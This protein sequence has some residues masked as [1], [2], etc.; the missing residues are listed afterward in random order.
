MNGLPTTRNT[1]S[2]SP[3]W[4]FNRRTL[5][6]IGTVSIVFVYWMFLSSK[7][8]LKSSLVTSP[9][10]ALYQYQ[11]AY[12]KYTPSSTIFRVAI[13]ADP[14]KRSK[15]EEKG[16]WQSKLR[17]GT[18]TRDPNTGNYS[19]LWDDE[20]TI[21]ESKYS[22]AGRSM[23]LSELVNFNHKLL[24]VDDRTGIVYSIENGKAIPQHILME[25][26]GQ[27]TKGFKAEWA[28]VKDGLLYIG[29]T[30]KEW[31]TPQGQIINNNPMWVKTIDIHGKI[32]HLDWSDRYEAM[33]KVTGGT[34]PGYLLHESGNWNPVLRQW[35][36]LP[37]RFST[38]EYDDTKDEERATNL[39]IRADED[40]LDLQVYTIGPLSKTRGFSSFAFIPG[41]ETEVVAIKSEEFRDKIASYITVFDIVTGAI[42]MPETEI[43]AEKYEG[44]EI[45]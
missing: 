8:P 43:E 34:H 31:T 40:F 35:F 14:D 18:L 16:H 39:V 1:I 41:R 4:T 20:E 23:E 36:F 25:G 30:G 10:D 22:E 37:R 3:K 45:L 32:T 15:N 44:I 38:E 19:I 42:L 33:R 29:G 2:G 27:T 9:R 21:L 24:T 13:V 6:L 17:K 26:N 12:L 11:S 5:I 7:A 28:T